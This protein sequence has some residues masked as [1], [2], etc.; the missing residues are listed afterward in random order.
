MKLLLPFERCQLNPALIVYNLSFYKHQCLWANESAV[1]IFTNTDNPW[2]KTELFGGK[3][4]ENNI[5]DNNAI[6]S[7]NKLHEIH[8]QR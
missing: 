7:G 2:I 6:K 4:Y 3:I 1:E 8:T 5:N